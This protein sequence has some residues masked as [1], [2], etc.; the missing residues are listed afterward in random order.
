MP[1]LVLGPTLR[2]VSATEA[3]VWVETDGPCEVAILDRVARTFEVAG[4]HYALVILEG[5]SPGTEHPYSVTLDGDHVWPL[6]GDVFPPCAI[7]TLPATGER[8]RVAFGSCRVSVPHHEPYTLP[9]DQDPRGR[10]ID[11]AYA[12]TRR[13][14]AQDPA[15]WPHAM[16]WLGD[17]VYADEVSPRTRA[18]IAR[19]RGVNS[20]PRNEVADFEEYTRLYRES[21]TDPSVRWLLSTVSGSMIWD[22]HDVHDDWNTSE[23]WLH[24]MR[25]RSWWDERIVGAIMSYWLYQHIGNLSPSHLREDEMFGLACEEREI[26]GALRAFALRADR[27]TA[28]TR[29]SYCRDFGATR[30][31]V[32]DSRAGRVLEGDAR[33]MVDEQEWEWISDHAR[34]EFDHLLLGTTLPW[35]LAPG[36]HHLE[37]WNEAVCAGAWGPAAARAGERM[38]QGLDLEHWAAFDDSFDRLAGLTREIGAGE[39]GAPP[40]ASIVALSGDVHHAYLA[41]V[42]YPRGAGVRSNVWQAVCSPLRN[43]LDAHE[44]AAVRIAMRPGAAA[45][46]HALARSAGVED[47]PIRWRVCDGPWFDN[48]IATLDVEGRSLR[49]EIER[50]RP[51]DDRGTEPGGQRRL[52]T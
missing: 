52:E 35:L 48:Q 28:G 26:T 13:M 33:R 2:Y 24:E 5:L 36:M 47:P 14:R 38:R 49:L 6:P 21:W 4:H 22:D 7:R 16:L 19:R 1:E 46:T 18:L 27:E 25:R 45:L 39:H 9:R 17:Q 10:E 3:T 8:V 44:R 29:W 23:A 20:E 51:G 12:L 34:G 11:A 41:N 32:L 42:A 43:P 37:A 40:P 30:L 31:L 50:A 15:E